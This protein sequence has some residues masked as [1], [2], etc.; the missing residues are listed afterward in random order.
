MVAESV[1]GSNLLSLPELVGVVDVTV[2]RDADVLRHLEGTREYLY[3]S[4]I[5]VLNKFRRQKIATVM[6]EACDVLSC[7]WGFNHLALR[8]YEE[9]SA[10][11]KL[12]L[13]AGY[14]VVSVDPDWMTLIGRKRR[15]LMIKQFTSQSTSNI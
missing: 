4:G 6:L 5:A 11:Q 2:Q 12:Y 3:V 1:E 8:A 9:D 7:R 13:K 10:A 14:R 15:V